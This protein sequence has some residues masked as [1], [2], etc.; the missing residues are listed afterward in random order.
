MSNQRWRLWFAAGALAL[1]GAV[2]VGS[3]LFS[4][5]FSPRNYVADRYVRAPDQ[6]L[7][8]G[9]AIAYTSSGPPTQVADEI[10]GEW[11]PADRYVD[12]SGVYLR[13]ADDVIAVLPLTVGSLILVEAIRTAYPRYYGVV[14]GYWGWR[15]GTEGARGG[16]PGGGK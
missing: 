13:Y 16:G 1:A 7:D 8:G 11:R 2:M 6:D 15:T 10:A 3:A 4:G 12:G 5:D 14:G 9:A